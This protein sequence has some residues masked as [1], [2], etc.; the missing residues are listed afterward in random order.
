MYR[1]KEAWYINYKVLVKFAG[2]YFVQFPKI[3]HLQDYTV[4]IK[5][6]PSHS[7]IAYSITVYECFVKW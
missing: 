5:D 3:P 2:N 7:A 6:Y 4:F 1:Y